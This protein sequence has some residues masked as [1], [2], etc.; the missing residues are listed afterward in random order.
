MTIQAFLTPDG[1]VLTEINARFGGGFPLGCAAG[2]AYPA[3]LVD[4]VE[5]RT[6]APRLRDYE[7]GLFM[8]RY[9]VEHYT[10]HPVW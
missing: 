4:M 8:S 2:A 5:G 10:R 9:Y 1:P 3:W 7:P 6:V